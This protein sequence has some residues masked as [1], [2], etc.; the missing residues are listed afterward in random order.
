M[1]A[2]VS[3][4]SKRAVVLLSGGMDSAVVLAMAIRDGFEAHALTFLYGQRHAVEIDFARRVATTLGAARHVVLALDIGRFGGSSLTAPGEVPRGRER[5][6]DGEIPST[7]VP[8]RNAVF[9]SVA[10]SLAEAIGARDVFIGVSAVDYSGYPDCRPEF[11]RAFEAAINVGTRE[12]AAGRG[13]RLHAPLL[14]MSKADTVR[15]GLSLGVDFG[16]TRSCYDPAADGTPCGLCDACRLRA[17]GFAGAGA[18][19]PAVP[20]ARRA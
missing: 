7:Y 13:F 8:A 2:G 12:G 6:G 16:L 20:P 19:D 1:E 17:I 18:T 10:V 11:L 3:E 5:S 15:A 9:L 4:S 14:E